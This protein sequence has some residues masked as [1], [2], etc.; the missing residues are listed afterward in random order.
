VKYIFIFFDREKFNSARGLMMFDV[1]EHFY[2]PQTSQ[3]KERN[4]GRRV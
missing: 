4:R 3:S 1:L 2:D